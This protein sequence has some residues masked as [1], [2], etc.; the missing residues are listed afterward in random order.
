MA[1]WKD[2]QVLIVGGGIGG[3]TAALALAGQGIPSQVIEQA[4]AFK[5]I[6]AGIQL[7]PNV[8]RMF[9]KLGLIEPIS[10][11]AVFPN[12]LIMFDSITGEEVTRIS[13]G[14]A[15]RKK[16]HYPYA[17]IHRADLHNVLL[18]H[19]RKS[20]LI[21]LDAAQKI[22]DLDEA[23]GAVTA[24]TAT[25]KDYRGAALIGAD[26]LWST[27]R[28]FVVGDGK[29]KPAGHITYRAVL[30]TS[31]VPE[32]YRWWNMG[33]WAGEKV[34]FVLYPLRTGE[35]YNLVA[36]FHSNRYEEGW[37]SYGD[38]AELHERF[39]A[40]C[41]PVRALLNK[42]ESWR[43][44]V[45]CDRPPVKDWS[46]GRIT[47]LGDAAHPMLQYLAQGACMAVEDAVCLAD[48]AVE[49]NGD[50][51]AAFRAYQAVRYLRTGR[52]QI[53]ARVYG[54]FYHAGGVAKELRNIML[55]SRTPDD[56]MAGMEWLYGE[57]K[58]L[59]RGLQAATAN[60]RK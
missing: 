49:M 5:E 56:A 60:H 7:G 13:L 59:T 33:F 43:M 3:L 24:K 44:W 9:E 53:M 45:L 35:L 2:Q 21:K 46:K 40:T 55:G 22:V 42:I 57:Q 50:Y 54:E 52:V 19:C 28:E 30:P 29:P 32:Q 8:F 47:L 25:G 20:N 17:L 18:E 6:G 36:V 12:N 14:D 4:A 34:H 38:P 48:K 37:D 41:E 11:L 39:A 15:F 58:E 23:N 10:A 26:G 1:S 31:E 27:I 51:A 16:F